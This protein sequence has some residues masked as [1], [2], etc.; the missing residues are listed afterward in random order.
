MQPRSI[1]V[2]GASRG[3]GRAIALELARQGCQVTLNARS[4]DLLAQVQAE[5]EALGG[6]ATFLAGDISQ[7]DVAER[8]VAAAVLAFGRLDGIINNAAVLEPLARIA[9]SDPMAWQRN[10]EI[11]VMGP[12]LLT[13]AALP[14]LRR[15]QGRVINIS[16][17]AAVRPTAGW[18]A[19]CS[20]KAALN[21][22]TAVLAEEEPNL[23][24]LAVRPGVVDTA[25]QAILRAQGHQ[26]MKPEVYQR[27]IDYHQQQALLPPEKPARS[28]AALA[29]QAPL[30][31]SGRFISWDDPDVLALIAEGQT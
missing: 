28:I 26:A 27:F 17:G 10:L 1:I 14:Y 21:M 9:D 11:N 31:W 20:S 12:Y 18:S 24:A 13:Q 23:V 5:I 22:F 3:L 15:T 4:Q 19:Y 25:M 7:P 30:A 29:L 16:S 2:T 8:L 6:Q